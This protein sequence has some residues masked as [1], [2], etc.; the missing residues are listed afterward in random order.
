MREPQFWWRKDSVAARLL[1][2]A[3]ALYGAMART[4]LAARGRHAAAPVICIGNLVL[5]GA[6]KTPTAIAIASLL[7]AMQEKPI[8]L[9]RGYG[10]R[11]QG[12][13]K[14]EPVAHR[15]GDLLLRCSPGE[16]NRVHA[17]TWPNLPLA[18]QC[19]VPRSET[20]IDFRML[21][22]ARSRCST[23]RKNQRGGRYPKCHRDPFQFARLFK[24]SDK[25]PKHR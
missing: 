4:R 9:T 5:G 15:A 19:L 24:N 1:V 25:I 7:R 14:V 8:F 18:H 21:R 17:H 2:P 13:V 10:G 23:T 3:G 16:P 6:G 22:N 11:L 20:L 12:P